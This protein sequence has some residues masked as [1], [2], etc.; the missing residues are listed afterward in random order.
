MRRQPHKRRRKKRPQSARLPRFEE[1]LDRVASRWN[2]DASP[3]V[4]YHYTRWAG[5]EGIVSS[6]RFWDSIMPA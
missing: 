1:D 5:F 6:Q 4:L 3:P 2:R